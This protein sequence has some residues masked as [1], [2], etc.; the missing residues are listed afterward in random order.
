MILSRSERGPTTRTDAELIAAS[1][2]DPE[3]FGDIF[4]RHFDAIYRYVASR[5]GATLVDDLASEV[6]SIAFRRRASYRLDRDDARPWLYGIA[7]N[8]LHRQYRTE[9]RRLQAYGRTDLVTE[10]FDVA[11]IVE[12][13]DAGAQQARVAAALATLAPGDRDVLLLFAGADQ[14]YQDIADALGIPIGTV[15]SRLNRARRTVRSRLGLS[16]EY[17]DERDVSRNPQE[18]VVDGR[19]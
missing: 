5:L 17:H 9:Q 2:S 14:S 1:K 19:T 18:E 11:A 3:R 12:R 6:F 8:L 4:D 16:G 7:T 15:R 13:V 10:E